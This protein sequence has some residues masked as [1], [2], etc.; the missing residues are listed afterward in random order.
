VLHLHVCGEDQ[1]RR[2]RQLFRGRPAR[3]PSR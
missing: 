1:E 2:V 3:P